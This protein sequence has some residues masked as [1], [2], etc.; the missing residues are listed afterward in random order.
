MGKLHNKEIFTLVLFIALGFGS[1]SFMKSPNAI[2]YINR[3]SPVE[4]ISAHN[5]HHSTIGGEH[6]T[7]I[8][9]SGDER[10]V[11]SRDEALQFSITNNFHASAAVSYSYMLADELGN[12]IIAEP[13]SDVEILASG[14]LTDHWLD[15]PLSLQEG[16]YNLQVTV[17]GRSNGEFADSGVD[18]NFAILNN[19][20]YMLNN[21][22]WMKY[23]LANRATSQ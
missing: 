5:D 6:P 14:E 20:I 21:E 12:E 22:E 16:L 1:T 23:S 13:T 11:F 2:Q 18:L 15:I 7:E 17:V 9:V 3:I 19:K 4:F 10:E 8:V